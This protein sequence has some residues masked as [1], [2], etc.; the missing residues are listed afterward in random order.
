MPLKVRRAVVVNIGLAF[1]PI[2]VLVTILV[3]LVM[4]VSYAKTDYA[5]LA[6][7]DK[8]QT[9]VQISK[10]AYA[11]GVDGL[12]VVSGEDHICAAAAAVLA[13]AYEGPMLVTP[14]GAVY[15]DL[16][17]EI[18]RLGPSRIF[19]VGTDASVASV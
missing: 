3:L 19:V 4:P 14:T 1:G 2:C 8:Y 11:P 10:A 15:P 13:A 12:V 7:D 18:W 9:A 6:A 16:V 5:S 17:E